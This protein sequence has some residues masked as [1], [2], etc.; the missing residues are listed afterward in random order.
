LHARLEHVEIRAVGIN[1]DEIPDFV[2]A[3]GEKDFFAVGRP[4]GVIRIVA[5]HVFEDVQLS[6]RK[7]DDCD[8]THVTCVTRFFHGVKRDASS[9]R[10]DR[11]ENSISDLFLAS[12]VEVCDPDSLVAFERDHLRSGKTRGCSEQEK[13]YRQ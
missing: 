2:R 6:G 3:R 1:S 5:R 4:A 13:Q 7:F 9:I 10:R 8:V 11:R 12:A